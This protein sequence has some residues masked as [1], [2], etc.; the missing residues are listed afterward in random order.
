MLPF[1][2][3]SVFNLRVVLISEGSV[4]CHKQLKWQYM[5]GDILHFGDVVQ[6]DETFEKI[7][8]CCINISVHSILF[9]YLY[10]KAKSGWLN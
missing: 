4:V 10:M 2:S 3:D 6:C 7:K 5:T 1:G 9:V 8:V